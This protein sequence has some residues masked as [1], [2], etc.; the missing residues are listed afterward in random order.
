MLQHFCAQCGKSAAGKLIVPD[1]TERPFWC[2]RESCGKELV[3][4]IR[5]TALYPVSRLS[6]YHRTEPVTQAEFRFING[7]WRAATPHEINR[8]RPEDSTLEGYGKGGEWMD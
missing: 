3:E 7:V 6:I 8:C 4:R 1:R 2:G 5:R